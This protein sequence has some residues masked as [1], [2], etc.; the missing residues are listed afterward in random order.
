MAKSLFPKEFEPYAFNEVNYIRSTMREL[1]K[2]QAMG[3]NVSAEIEDAMRYAKKYPAL[4]E[5][6]SAAEAANGRAAKTPLS[7]RLRSMFVDLG[8][9]AVRRR[10]QAYQLA[11]KLERGTLDSKFRAF[12][13][14][15]GFS[16][17]LGCAD[18]LLRRVIAIKEY[19]ARAAGDQRGFSNDGTV[20]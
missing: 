3:V 10:I 6:L 7:G 16:T 13:D 4:I 2:R 19:P 18:F 12:G 11:Q 1:R 15:F 20:L 17:V 9:R 5:N 8:A 14:D